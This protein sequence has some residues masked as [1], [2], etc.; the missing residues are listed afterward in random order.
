MSSSKLIHLKPTLWRAFQRSVARHEKLGAR[1]VA[2]GVDKADPSLYRR[3]DRLRDRMYDL[4]G[5][6]YAVEC[7]IDHA[8]DPSQS[9]AF[10]AFEDIEI[11][12]QFV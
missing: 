3:L 5:Q 1:I 6:C 2:I 12:I 11:N 10:P 8:I 4:A 9:E 7:A